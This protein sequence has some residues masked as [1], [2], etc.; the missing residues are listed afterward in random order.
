L[1]RKRKSMG[2]GKKKLG[3]GKEGIPK[4]KRVSKARKKKNGG[5][6]PKVARAAKGWGGQGMPGATAEEKIAN[7]RLSGKQ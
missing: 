6:R 4:K 1:K 7:A 2:G 5:K 3:G